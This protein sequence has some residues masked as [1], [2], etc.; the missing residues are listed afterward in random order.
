[1]R[2]PAPINAAPTTSTGAT[3]K[4]VRGSVP[5]LCAVADCEALAGAGVAAGAGLVAGVVAGVVVVVFGVFGFAGVLPS[6]S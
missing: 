2:S 4:P 6:G 1:M 5:A 3:G